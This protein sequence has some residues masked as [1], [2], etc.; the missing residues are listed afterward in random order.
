[1]C[2]KS[3]YQHRNAGHQERVAVG[4]RARNR[5]RADETARADA[6]IDVKLLAESRAQRVSIEATER[7]SSAARRERHDHAYGFRRPLRRL[8]IGRY[9]RNDGD[10]KRNDTIHSYNPFRPHQ[11]RRQSRKFFKS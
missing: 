8:D 6:I 3:Q 5:C 1:M 9:Q 11:G 2:V 10:A 7:V 4:L